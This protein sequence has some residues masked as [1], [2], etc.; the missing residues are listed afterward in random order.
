MKE[1]R[2]MDLIQEQ[3]ARFGRSTIFLGPV[4]RQAELDLMANNDSFFIA[5][6]PSET[7]NF[8]LT[9]GAGKFSSSEFLRCR[10]AR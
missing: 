4:I 5:K 8:F 2:K 10:H 6:G 9:G 1:G 7:S 3:S